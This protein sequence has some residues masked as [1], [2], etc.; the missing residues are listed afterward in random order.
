MRGCL[1][2]G[3]RHERGLEKGEGLAFFGRDGERDGYQHGWRVN[4]LLA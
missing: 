3:L 4:W 1:I 2:S